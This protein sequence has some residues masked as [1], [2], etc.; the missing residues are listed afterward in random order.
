[1]KPI[2]AIFTTYSNRQELPVV[3]DLASGTHEHNMFVGCSLNVK[4]E[5]LNLLISSTMDACN[6][7]F[8][9]SHEM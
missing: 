6:F 5:I 9:G 3:F 7:P 8:K 2:I 4:S 1:M